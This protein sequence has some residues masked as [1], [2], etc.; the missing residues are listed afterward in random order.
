MEPNA[1]WELIIKTCVGAGGVGALLLGAVYYL[2]RSNNG[3]LLELKIERETRIKLLETESTDCKR[4]RSELHKQ[5]A[6]LKDQVIEV[7][8]SRDAKHVAEIAV[9]ALPEPR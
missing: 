2:N 5:I 4:D 3:L 1:I 6:N 9:K 8:R 7:Y